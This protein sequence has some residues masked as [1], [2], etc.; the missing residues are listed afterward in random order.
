M[1]T[2]QDE[3]QQETCLQGDT[4]AQS[5][6]GQLT[7]GQWEVLLTL[8]EELAESAGQFEVLAAGIKAAQ[9][10][11]A[12]QSAL[13]TY[14]DQLGFVCETAAMLEL[15]ALVEVVNFIS[16]SLEQVAAE[17]PPGNELVSALATW[18]ENVRDWLRSPLE[19]EPC[20]RLVRFLEQPCWPEP[21]E[22]ETSHG[23]LRQ[24]T[25]FSA[26]ACDDAD[27]AEDDADGTAAHY[28]MDAVSL[29]IAEDA[30]QEVLTAFLQDAP[31]YAETLY[32]H[33]NLLFDGQAF[34]SHIQ[35]AQ[36]ASHTLK[37][38]AN[39]LGIR[40]VANVSHE[41]ERI[42]DVLVEK[43]VAPNTDDLQLMIRAADMIGAMLDAL[44]GQEFL[45]GEPDP[46]GWDRT[47]EGAL[48]ILRELAGWQYLAA[49][50]VVAEPDSTPTASTV[51]PAEATTPELEQP[52]TAPSA[53]RMAQATDQLLALSENLNINLVQTKSLYQGILRTL[54]QLTAQDLVIQERRFSL[55]NLVDGRSMA[56]NVPGLVALPQVSVLSEDAAGLDPLEMDRYDTLHLTTHQFIEA[57]SDAKSF[58]ERLHRQ[59]VLFDQLIQQ[60]SRYA[61][62]VQHVL[63]SDRRVP[64]ATQMSRLQ[65]CV[66]Q[67]AHMAGKQA[68]LEVQGE[69]TSIDREQLSV[70]LDALMHLIRNAIDHGIEAPEAREAHGKPSIGGVQLTIRR[71]NQQVVLTLTDDGQGVDYDQ[72]YFKAVERG[73]LPFDSERPSEERLAELLF[74]PGFS[75][76][77][78]AT[79]L[80]GRGIGLDAVRSAL[81]DIGGQVTLQSRAKE[82]AR[83]TLRVPER[84]ITEHCLVVRINEKDYA[85]PSRQV[86]RILPDQ[87]GQMTRLAGEPI[88]EVA[89]VAYLIRPLAALLQPEAGQS[90]SGNQQPVYLLLTAGGAQ[91]AVKVDR[92]TAGV[93]LVIKKTGCLVSRIRDVLGMSILGDGSLVPALDLPALLLRLKD[94][95]TP[96]V[97][98]TRSQASPVPATTT[99]QVEVL[100][101]DDSLSVRT[102]L[103]QLLSDA[104]FAVVTATDGMDAVEILSRTTPTLILVDMEMPRMNG[105]ELTRFVR[106]QDALAQIPMIMLTSRSQQKHREMALAAGV[107]RYKTKPY[108][109]LDLL[110]TVYQVLESEAITDRV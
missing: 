26:L 3:L 61:D 21:L 104:G 34:I 72:V 65:R 30:I 39:L 80:S 79:Q 90:D 67:A 81:T 53:P 89:D 101:V 107:T 78:Q 106:H 57:V 54:N 55:E 68:R 56:A 22:G 76:R 70:V 40:G 7:E 84:Q 35:V 62:S 44:Q 64:I 77:D 110:E 11:S 94:G 88:L 45:Q 100:V 36:R 58:T 92:V 6:R 82:G 97:G 27:S 24:L 29:T 75:T 85:I 48:D 38:G 25:D 23:L 99:R 42:L 47:P 74:H 5:S 109:D 59:L 33:I 43:N 28:D 9:D 73:L 49:A 18:P 13:M 63:L 102:S 83:F 2:F 41:L 51:Q 96:S 91:W 10:D 98:T 37:G 16:Y 71:E 19:D 50:H 17:Q 105:L 52:A 20:L 14:Q 15:H 1:G 69:Q 4:D 46:G 31:G 8:E 86:D 66:R 60:Q 93:D 32:D 103:Q 87:A 95:S 108:Q 12:R